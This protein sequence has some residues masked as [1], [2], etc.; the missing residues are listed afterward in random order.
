MKALRYRTGVHFETFK[1]L[2]GWAHVAQ[3][4]QIIWTTRLDVRVMALDFG[5]DHF[6]LL[7]E[8]VTP[9]IALRLYDALISAAHKHEPEYRIH[10]MQLVR[11]TR[12]GGLGVRHAGT[13]YPEGRFGNYEDKADI[14]AAV[15]APLALYREAA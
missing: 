13:Y 14:E 11:L 7:A 8:D 5:S 15:S 2:T 3:S 1:P 4:L 10:S 12:K 6:G 9:D